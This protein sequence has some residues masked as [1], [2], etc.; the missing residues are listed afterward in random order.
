VITSRRP[1]SALVAVL[2]GA[3]LLTG[4]GGGSEV[5]AG[6]Y[7]TVVDPPFTVSTEALR[8]TAGTDFRLSR[9]TTAPLSLI[10]FGY[11]HC[12]DICPA[13]LS[14]VASALTKLTRAQQ[15]QV[16]LYF[17]TT[18]PQRDTPAVLSTYV[19]HFD[20][21]FKALTGD[22]PTIATVAK[23]IGVFVDK[24]D[25]LATGGYDPN[26]H[27]SYV[28]GINAKHQAPIFWSGDTAPSEFA[29][30]F[31]FLLTEKPDHLTSSTS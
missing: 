1:L 12:P 18:D 7:G 13:V 24:G 4:C 19:A 2:L 30:D 11:T 20:P 16:Q 8:T 22:L 17:V 29:S 9:D 3:L 10:F 5:K 31:T 27:G 23:S 6:L 25:P 28:I 26:S 14:S 15:E 21:H